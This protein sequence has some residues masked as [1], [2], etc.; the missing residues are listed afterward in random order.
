MNENQDVDNH[1][2]YSQCI[3]K[4]S[5]G[6][7]LAEGL[8]HPVQP[9]DPIQPKDDRAGNILMAFGGKQKVGKISGKDAYNVNK[10]VRTFDIIFP[11]EFGILDH[12]SLFKIALVHADEDVSNIEK[13]TEV[14]T[15]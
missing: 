11:Q 1:L 4:V 6:L 12:Q 9:G 2:G 13:F 5:P 15:N 7:S 14:V 8:E 3:W 10:K